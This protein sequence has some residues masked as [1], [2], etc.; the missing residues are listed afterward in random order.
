M[1]KAALTLREIDAATASPAV[2]RVEAPPMVS[3]KTWDAW[4]LGP[5]PPRMFGGRTD[6][7]A[8]VCA[9]ATQAAA[10]IEHGATFF[11]IG[12]WAGALRTSDR[13]LLCGIQWHKGARP[14]VVWTNGHHPDPLAAL[15]AE[16]TAQLVAHYDEQF[17]TRRECLDGI[18]RKL[19]TAFDIRFELLARPYTKGQF[20]Y[21]CPTLTAWQ[22]RKCEAWIAAKGGAVSLFPLR[23]WLDQGVMGA[24]PS[25]KLLLQAV[26]G[27]LLRRGHA[28]ETALG[29]PGPDYDDE[30]ANAEGV[31]SALA[32]HQPL[33]DA[34]RACLDRLCN[35]AAL[36]HSAETVAAPCEDGPT[37]TDIFT[38]GDTP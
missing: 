30:A 1:T 14:L 18:S 9:A 31:R 13:F 17:V 19:N 34:A 29:Q 37:L 16:K 25:A 22:R 24:Q 20:V 32:E 27:L 6:G 21:V 2:L 7:W 15:W 26:L 36:R 28:L 23:I 35:I 33:I 38:K 10:V 3:L 8:L 12:R 5:R 4:E 11:P